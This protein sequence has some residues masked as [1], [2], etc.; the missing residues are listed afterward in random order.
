MDNSEDN[1]GAA[2]EKPDRAAADDDSAKNQPDGL[3]SEPRHSV[4]T[5]TPDVRE[6]GGKDTVETLTTD[7]QSPADQDTVETP[8]PVQGAADAPTMVLQESTQDTGIALEVVGLSARG[9]H[10]PIFEAVGLSVPPSGLALIA[11]RGGSGRT[12]LL[13]ALAGRFPIAAGSVSVGDYR[14]PG[15]AR[16][17]RRTVSVARARP[18][19]DLDENLRVSELIAERRAIAGPAVTPE[20]VDIALSTVDLEV[21]SSALVGD[22]IPAHR[23]LLA[24]ALALSERRGVVVIDDIDEGA[25]RDDLARIYSAL[26]AAASAGPTI[27]ATTTI[28]PDAGAVELDAAVELVGTEG[29]SR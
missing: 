28:L 8:M 14:L 10:G 1:D 20:S 29:E 6:P 26:R 7:V 11:G 3:P 18:P 4:D 21:A 23:T 17:V 25:S 2:G 9:R 13:L 19:I 27:V 24:L 22:L 15:D 16:A 5:P 12:S